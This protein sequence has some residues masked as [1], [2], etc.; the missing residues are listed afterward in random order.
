MSWF[1]YFNQTLKHASKPNIIKPMVFDMNHSALVN[2][3]KFRFLFTK[4]VTSMWKFYSPM[5]LPLTLLLFKAKHQ[6]SKIVNKTVTL[7]KWAIVGSWMIFKVPSLAAFHWFQSSSVVPYKNYLP[8][9]HQKLIILNYPANGNNWKYKDTLQN[10][11]INYGTSSQSHFVCFKRLF[12]IYV[13]LTFK[14]TPHI[15]L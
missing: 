13:S 9:L 8:L 7:A 6:I 4:F 1:K 14:K 3:C 15:C 10:S 12:Y 2:I 11:D 5:V